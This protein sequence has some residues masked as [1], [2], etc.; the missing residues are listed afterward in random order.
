MVFPDHTHLLFCINSGPTL[1]I[2]GAIH[3]SCIQSH[4]LPFPEGLQVRVVCTLVL[5]YIRSL[6]F[7]FMRVAKAKAKL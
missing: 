1:R 2:D 7:K 5:F 4:M 3:F 6:Y